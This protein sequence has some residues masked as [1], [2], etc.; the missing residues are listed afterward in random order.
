MKITGSCYCGEIKY[1]GETDNSNVIV[2]HCS[3]CQRMSSGPFRAVVVTKPNGVKFTRGEPK[4]YIKTAQSGNKRA[5]G[6]CAHCGTSL[7]A[8]NEAKE[9][10]VYGM[11]LGSVDQ[12]DEFS[13]AAQIWTQSTLTWLNDLHQVTAFETTP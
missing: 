6:F 9:D 10:R 13:P 4:E 3:D 8:T 2:C 12:R 11:R 7:Y 5:Q 1:E